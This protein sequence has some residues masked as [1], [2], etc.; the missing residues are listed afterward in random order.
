MG[1]QNAHS[2]PRSRGQLRATVIPTGPADRVLAISPET[3]EPAITTSRTSS[4]SSTLAVRRWAGTRTRMPI[5]G[6]A[7]AAVTY[8]P[9]AGAQHRLALGWPHHRA[10]AAHAAASAPARRLATA[11]RRS[12]PSSSPGD[13]LQPRLLRSCPRSAISAMHRCH[14]RLLFGDGRRH[15]SDSPPLLS[16][17]S[18]ERIRSRRPVLHR[19]LDRLLPPIRFATRPTPCWSPRDAI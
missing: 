3:M 12:P 7:V 8:E 14:S 17:C 13:L 16:A 1:S 2:S 19:S 4:A 11:G 5:W 18:S 10:L 9:S 6:F 15:R